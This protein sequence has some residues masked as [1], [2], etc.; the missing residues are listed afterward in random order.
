MSEERCKSLGEK[1]S[2]KIIQLIINNK[3]KPGDKLPNEYDLAEEL[4]VGRSTIREAIKALVSR[5][6]LEIRRGSGTFISEKC[7]IA[8]DP[9]GLIFVKDKI[10]LAVDLL[11]IRFMIEPKIAALAAINATE[12][13]ILNMERICNEVED[14]ILSG[15]T[16]MNKDIEFHGAIAKSSKNIVT[17]NLVPIINKSISVFIDVTNTQLK[18]ETIETHREI[19]N[20]IK[21]RDS[22]GAHD[23]MMIH[24]V[25]NR[26]SINNRI[27][28]I[29]N[30]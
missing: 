18:N 13:E 3:L 2:E 5:N 25:H 27:N 9:L 16:H 10:K 15:S 14:L 1:A 19:L 4:G 24:L 20:A 12:E 30:K 29:E 8:E 6:V 7:G 11:E 22:V 28:A 17:A 23:A 21:N 26:R